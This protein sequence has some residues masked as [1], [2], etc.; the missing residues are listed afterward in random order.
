MPTPPAL[1]RTLWRLITSDAVRVLVVTLVSLVVT[2]AFAASIKPLADQK[3]AL[4]DML[5]LMG[6]LAIPMLQFALPFA[7]GFSTTIAYHRFTADNEASAAMAAGVSHRSL[8]VPAVLLGLIVGGTLYALLT[9]IVPTF[10]REAEQLVRRDIT[11]A[12]IA[13]VN[14]GQTIHIDANGL[15]VFAERSFEFVPPE[16]SGAAQALRLEGVLAAE[17]P[18]PGGDLRYIT[19]DAVNVFIYEVP[20]EAAT[21]LRFEFERASGRTEEGQLESQSIFTRRM[22]VPG[23]FRDD[24]KFRSE[25]E[26]R[27]ALV[28]PRAI[29]PIDRAARALEGRLTRER[30]V[31]RIA[32]ALHPEVGGVIEFARD[33]LAVRAGADLDQQH[34][35]FARG[36]RPID[37]ADPPEWELDPQRTG[38]IRLVRPGRG[39]EFI[40]H[41]AASGRLR[42]PDL[43][44]ADLLAVPSQDDPAASPEFI[45]E[46][47]DVATWRH[48][49]P[50]ETALA[51]LRGEQAGEAL[52]DAAPSEVS[53]F[54]RG[55][56]TLAATGEPL[57]PETGAIE[58]LVAAGFGSADPQTERAAKRLERDVADLI[59]EIH[60]K[61]HER[62]AT[63]VAGFFIVV[64]SAV[65]A[66]RR[67]MAMPV[68]AYL[69]AFFPTL[70][71][72][73]LI[74]TG[75][76]LAHSYGTPGLF[77]LWGGLVALV[78]PLA[79]EFHKL[80][81]H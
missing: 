5:V 64:L 23:S 28:T 19:A 42:T 59:L 10:L 77:V 27:E 35:L 76:G 38:E 52:D 50:S 24:P 57:E 80:A 70:A 25:R 18:G 7:A 54:T 46:L 53:V 2:I 34:A 1:P 37:G 74:G 66:L 33:A 41:R 56:L 68:P 3:I 51:W 45:L 31:E 61:R 65:V 81:R 73:V 8:L 79:I 78:I 47:R 67:P 48:D 6:L 63:S 60:S 22:R 21:E 72:V 16:G 13:P 62:M 55:G 20:G 26:L 69:F 29:E 4:G 44:A 32:L 9:T 71:C 11:R 12:L 36:L 30:A 75:Q 49:G 43:Q 58:P 39:D 15:E 17:T 40:L 14:R